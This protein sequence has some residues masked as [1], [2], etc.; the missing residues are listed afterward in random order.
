MV[1]SQYFIGSKHPALGVI[2]KGVE[3]EDE[4]KHLSAKQCDI[5]QNYFISKPIFSDDFMYIYHA[6]LHPG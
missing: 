3:T 4:R 5:F 6:S 1:D 2:A